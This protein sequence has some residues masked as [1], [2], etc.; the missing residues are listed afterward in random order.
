VI[1]TAAIGILALLA[2]GRRWKGGAP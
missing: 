1:V 2:S